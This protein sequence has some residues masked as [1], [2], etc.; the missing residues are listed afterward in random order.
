MGGLR[1]NVWGDILVL[2]CIYRECGFVIRLIFL[3]GITEYG[4][5]R[6]QNPMYP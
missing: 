1:D 2:E 6:L 3:V 5:S 4:S